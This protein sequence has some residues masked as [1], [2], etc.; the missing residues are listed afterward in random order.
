MCAPHFFNS[1]R[2][3]VSASQ[4]TTGI[5]AKTLRGIASGCR[6][7][8]RG[9]TSSCGPTRDQNRI[10]S[11]VISFAVGGVTDCAPT[12]ALP[13]DADDAGDALPDDAV[14]GA[15]SGSLSGAGS[16]PPV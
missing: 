12:G 14:G 2:E 5:A 11:S 8:P 3:K 1:R 9:P 16:G 15:I 7:G 4:K 13:D 10:S 6:P